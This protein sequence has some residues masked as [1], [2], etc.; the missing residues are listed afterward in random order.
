[1]QLSMSCHHAS[2]NKVHIS[3]NS[4]AYIEKGHTPIQVLPVPNAYITFCDKTSKIKHHLSAAV[5][6]NVVYILGT[7]NT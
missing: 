2:H 7:G 5:C 1:M 6:L 3:G 4:Q